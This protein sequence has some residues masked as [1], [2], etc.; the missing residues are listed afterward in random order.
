MIPLIHFMT[1]L[2]TRWRFFKSNLDFFLICFLQI[3]TF[4][5]FEILPWFFNRLWNFLQIWI[6][7]IWDFPW[8][9][10][11]NLEIFPNPDFFGIFY[12]IGI[13]VNFVNLVILWF[14]GILWFLWFSRR[15]YCNYS[16]FGEFSLNFHEFGNFNEFYI[17]IQN[18]KNRIQK[19]ILMG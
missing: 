13:L 10:Y 6:F 5:K 4:W 1:V 8:I 16:E 17:Q 19:T 11:S 9:F 12:C 2:Y 18:K 14:R 7:G 15:I 3:R